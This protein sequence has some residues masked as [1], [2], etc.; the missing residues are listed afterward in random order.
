[1]MWR[2][3]W[4]LL[5]ILLSA[6]D[7]QAQ[8]PPGESFFVTA[9]VVPSRGLVGQQMNYVVM[10]YSDTLRDVILTPPAFAGMVQGE[11]RSVGSSVT[12]DG[13]QY[14]LV[15]FAVTIYPSRPGVLTIPPAQVMF[16]GTVL[17]ETET[18]EANVVKF[19]ADLPTD[20]PDGVSG[21]VGRHESRFSV[22]T[23]T[24][25]LGQ[26]IAAEYRIWGTG[27][28]AGLPAP[29]LILPEGWRAYLDPTQTTITSDGAVT[30][31]EKI[32]RW[33]II[34]DR[35]GPLSLG[36][37]PI[38]VYDLPTAAFTTLT[39]DAIALQVL[40]GA[41]G[42]I[43]RASAQAAL[44]SSGLGLPAATQTNISPPFDAIW[45][46]VPMSAVVV[47]ILQAILKLIFAARVESYR[48]NALNAAKARLDKAAKQSSAVAL[49]AMESAVEWYLHDKQIRETVGIREALILVESARYAPSEI[50][51][52]RALASTVFE[53]LSQAEAES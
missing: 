35:A 26:P 8:V 39:V 36:V 6:A 21:L 40:P 15:T 7:G 20:A 31:S 2:G 41:N 50:E 44:E 29:E 16:D 17:T 23:N 47:V 33:R 24:A 27:D 9:E 3:F 49:R 52:V 48:K 22:D 5:L 34:P 12:L 43:V 51:T 4:V 18:R 30:T 37:A 10:A 11:I 32:F 45:W 42:E 53:A 14:N 46:F 38:I 28:V 13:K 25:E 19:T 1:V